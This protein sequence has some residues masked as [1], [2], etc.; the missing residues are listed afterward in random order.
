MLEHPSIRWYSS[1]SHPLVRVMAWVV[2]I[3]PVRTISRKLPEVG[4]ILRDCTRGAEIVG[5]PVPTGVMRSRLKIQSEPHGDMGSQAEMT[6]PLSSWTP[7]VWV[8][9]R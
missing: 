3:H 4:R 2:K 6:W 9:I 8:P 5:T 1:V 7:E